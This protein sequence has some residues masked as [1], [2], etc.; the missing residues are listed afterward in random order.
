MV[1]ILKYDN[2]DH[3][4]KLKVRQIQV[5]GKSIGQI[6]NTGYEWY[7]DRPLTSFFPKKGCLYITDIEMKLGLENQKL[8]HVFLF[9]FCQTLISVS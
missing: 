5:L 1:K 4:I 6:N 8:L 9:H 2:P 3:K 7:R